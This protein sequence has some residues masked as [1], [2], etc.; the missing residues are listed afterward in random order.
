MYFQSKHGVR[1]YGL[2]NMTNLV[3]TLKAY[4]LPQNRQLQ[5]FGRAKSN[6]SSLS[7]KYAVDI[8]H[9]SVIFGFNYL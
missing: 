7:K 9:L 1:L 5:I 4:L 8:H 3:Q 6:N 2:F